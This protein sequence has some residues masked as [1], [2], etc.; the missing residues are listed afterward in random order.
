[1]A[2]AYF[3]WIILLAILTDAGRIENN[4]ITRITVYLYWAYDGEDIC[5]IY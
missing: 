1:M 5:H 3:K 4:I 2:A